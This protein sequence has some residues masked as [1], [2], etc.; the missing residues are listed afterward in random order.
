MAEMV[1]VEGRDA[2]GVGPVVHDLVDACGCQPAPL[3]KPMAGQVREAVT[4][5]ARLTQRASKRLRQ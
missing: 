4:I 2:G 5:H 3:A 1:R